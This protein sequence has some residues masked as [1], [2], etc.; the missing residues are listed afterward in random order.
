MWISHNK[1]DYSTCLMTKVDETK[2]WHKKL[3]H[4]NPK[5]ERNIIYK[6]HVKGLS[7]L[8]IEEEKVFG[9]Y[10]IGKQAN[11]PHKKLM[12]L[13]ISKALELLHKNLMEAY[14]SIKPM[15]GKIYL[16]VCG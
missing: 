12:C 14:T 6:E 16:C 13:S 15:R 1:G 7:K 5:S 3:S 9:E 10:Q 8:K 2:L 4:I 11:M